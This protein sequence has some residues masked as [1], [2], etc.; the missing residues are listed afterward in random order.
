MHV[1]CAVY[2]PVCGVREGSPSA[3]EGLASTGISLPR[4]SSE[5]AFS[6]SLRMCIRKYGRKS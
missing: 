3:R 6:L 2:V 4:S 1:S 5:A